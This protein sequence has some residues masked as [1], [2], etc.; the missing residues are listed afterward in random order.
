MPVN[1]EDLIFISYARE[2]VSWAERLYMDLR[3]QE[4]NCWLDIKCLS[5]GA[6]W[7]Y[8]ISNCIKKA[9]FFLLLISKNSINKRG[10]VQRE[11]KEGLDVLKEFP[12]NSIFIIPVRLDDTRPIDH[13]LLELNWIDL[14]PNYHDELARILSLFEGLDRSPLIIS[15]QDK[16]I[17]YPMAVVDKGQEV[18]ADVALVLGDRAA[19]SYAPFR[20]RKQFLQQFFDNIPDDS[21]YLDRSISFYVTVNTAARGVCLGKD[22]LKKYPK[23]IVLVVQNVYSSLVVRD[24]GVS[25][26][27][28]F[29]KKKRLI[30]IPYDAILE[31][32]VP[33]IGM[34][35]VFSES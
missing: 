24:E 9:R 21:I 29:D 13:D 19:I 20:T 11:I 4:L 15:T 35:I 18:I 5:P 27:L 28:S 8:E 12:V 34:N 31:I 2:D 30:G 10:V 16:V 26:V 1:S 25:I 33:E 7:K 14:L 22:I 6:R 3:K 17:T 23:E 32:S